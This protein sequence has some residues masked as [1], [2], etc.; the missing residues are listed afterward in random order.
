MSEEEKKNQPET[1]A[2]TVSAADALK[3]IADDLKQSGEEN[4]EENAGK[5]KKPKR[6]RTPE[7]E[8]ERALN[9]VK[10]RKKLKYGAL[11]TGITVVVIAIV[12]MLNVVCN[13]L[14]NRFHL[15]IDL[16]ANGLYEIDPQ[17]V[18][19]LQQL[20]KEV[21]IV[22]MAEDSALAENQLL[23]VASETMERFVSESGGYITL[24]YCDLTKNPDIVNKLTAGTDFD[25]E[26]KQFDVVVKSGDLVRV[27]AMQGD[28]I[29]VDN[30]YDYQ[31][32]GYNTKY[33]FIGEQAL[34]S[35]IMGV[36]DLNPVNV[37]VINQM[38]GEQI[39]HQYDSPSFVR[40]AELLEKNNYKTTEIDIATGE[41]PADTQL[42][43]LCAPY[44]DLSESQ[45]QKLT[46]YLNN[47]GKY[48]KDLL[49]FASPFQQREQK[50][51]SAFL[52]IWGLAVEDAFIYESDTASAQVVNTAMGRPISG[53]PVVSKT[54]DTLNSNI[55][56]SKLPIV[57]PLTR[58]VKLLFDQN[59]GR[60]TSALLQTYS[61]GYLAPFDADDSFDA[62]SAEKGQFN[63]AAYSTTTFTSGSD[64]YSGRLFVFGSSW[65]LDY[66]VAGS[67][68][69]YENA[70]YFVSLLNTITGKENVLT[71]AEKSLDKTKITI[72]ESQG[73]LIRNV[74]MFII[75]AIV[76]MIGVVVYVRRRNK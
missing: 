69:T 59:A 54:D 4:K 24:S 45:I 71:I 6:Q 57:A 67:A 21:E 56:S 10:R 43:I 75:P 61:T 36:T 20:N 31:T 51:L 8:K 3:E 49:Y 66:V 19:Y 2:E 15:N 42:V 65:M 62:D 27:L 38:N 14:D 63:A 48:G 40:M 13:V 29:R 64:S 46:D 73:I 70:N 18:D 68:G 60:T 17:T 72:T 11:A 76:A 30:D 12:V 52:E 39:Y 32:G 35:A 74:T 33:T 16:T 55:A 5:A 9:A 53:V 7:E 28:I 26:L 22:V 47:D 1:S 37:T 58:S 44:N 23:K 41:I 34:I 50:N 25:G